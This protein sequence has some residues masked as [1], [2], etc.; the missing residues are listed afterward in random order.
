MWFYRAPHVH[1]DSHLKYGLIYNQFGHFD[2]YD[3]STCQSLF[4]EHYVH[5]YV[6][7]GG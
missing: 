1:I 4:L 5:V 3:I 2:V 7:T 6:I